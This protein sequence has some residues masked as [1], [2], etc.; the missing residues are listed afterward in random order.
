MRLS[1]RKNGDDVT[2]YNQVTINGWRAA[3]GYGFTI[4]L[5]G[6]SKAFPDPV[7]IS[8]IRA[9]LTLA[10]PSLPLL[11]SLPASSQLVKCHSYS[12][13][14]EQLVFEFCL[15]K[16]QINV[17]EEHRKSGDLALN[18]GLHAL[19]SGKGEV[20]DTYDAKTATIPRE[21]WLT[22]LKQ[23]GFRQTLL[24]E[25]PVPYETDNLDLST[26]YAKA[27]EFI[28]IGHYKDAV[29]QCR[30][31]I[32]HAEKVRNDSNQSKEANRNAQV[33]ATRQEMSA[34]ERML[35]L[36]EQIKNICQLGAHGSESFTRS[37]SKA[38]LG[39]TMALLAEPTV[40]FYSDEPKQ[41]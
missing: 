41:I 23:S 28:E 14:N 34:N 40:G 3:G 25:V 11:K 27:Q 18:I 1:I 29:M 33:R 12:N 35:S 32:E 8:S 38:V 19:V 5:K 9:N 15:A 26:L 31:M 16:E 36:R 22:A 24:F 2:N 39:M 10:D 13:E 21:E 37:Q 17:L 7:F 20:F 6:T 30:H 4:V